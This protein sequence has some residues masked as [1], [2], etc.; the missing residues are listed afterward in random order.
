MVGV[1][2]ESSPQRFRRWRELMIHA[3]ELKLRI[4]SVIQAQY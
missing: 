3:A 2:T 1:A 4:V